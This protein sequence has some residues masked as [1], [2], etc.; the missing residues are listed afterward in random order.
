MISFIQEKDEF[1]SK[2]D[3]SKLNNDELSMLWETVRGAWLLGEEKKQQSRG[4]ANS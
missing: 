2:V 1:Y 3:L 4:I